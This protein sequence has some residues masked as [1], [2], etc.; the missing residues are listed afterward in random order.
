[1][2]NK[3]EKISAVCITSLLSVFA[4]AQSV[5][6]S[7]V[8]VPEES[9]IQFVKISGDND[10]VCMPIVQRSK[11]T[12]NWLTNKIL[13]ISPD[14]ESIAFVAVHA[15]ATNIFVKEIERQGASVQR[16]NR[17]SVLDFSYSPDGKNIVF[18]EAG[19]NGNNIFLTDATS[20]F[21]CR[22]ITS[23]NND[24]SPVY[25]NEMDKIFFSRSENNSSS[26]WSF[27]VE[28]R[29][30]S[31]YASGINP[32]P[33]M[34]QGT[35]LCVRINGFGKGEIW[36]INYNTGVE[37]CIVSDTE[38]SF[39]TPSLSPNGEWILF[40][41]ST[42]VQYGKGEYWNT[43]IYV[44]RSDG[45]QLTQLTYHVADDLSPVWSKYGNFIFF[46]SQRGSAEAKANI[47][48][49]DFPF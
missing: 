20:G 2:R 25:S 48:K 42:P 17:K 7:V 18:S 19:A 39:S 23:G 43:D 26:I 41:G 16:T 27:D 15:G 14:W 21:I 12:I 32:S 35:F 46:I 3:I 45:S 13:G 29:F 24:Y 40:T 49:I 31:S 6:Y 44:C 11:N 10:C 38:K 22:Q 8:S 1:M 5:D 37:E 47:W 30:L 36:R 9:G 28:Q 34:Q 4:S 33:T